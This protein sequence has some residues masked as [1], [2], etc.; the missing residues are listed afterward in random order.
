MSTN[1]QEYPDTSQEATDKAVSE[2]REVIIAT[3]LMIQLDLDT[4]ADLDIWEK[5]RCSLECVGIVASKVEEWA[6]KSGN[7]HVLIHLASPLPVIERI[8]IQ[9]AL[10]SDRKREFLSLRDVKA[11]Y[12]FPVMLFRPKASV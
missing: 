3:D 6:S 1:E 12:E 5:R 8:A 4:V 7:R 2:G 9:C 10:G 11:G